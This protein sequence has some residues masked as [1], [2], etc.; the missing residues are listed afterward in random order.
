MLFSVVITYKLLRRRIY[1]F[2]EFSVPGFVLFEYFIYLNPG[3]NYL[4]LISSKYVTGEDE[5]GP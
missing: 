1:I 2:L 5:S 3:F 4:W